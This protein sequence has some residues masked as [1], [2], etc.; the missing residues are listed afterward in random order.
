MHFSE[1]EEANND[2]LSPLEILPD[3]DPLTD[4]VAEHHDLQEKLRR[5]ID[6]LPPKF[7]SVVLLRYASQ[8]SF[9]EIGKVLHM[10]EATAKTYFQRARPL[11]RAALADQR[12]LSTAL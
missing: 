5:A 10:P 11:L 9:S 4:E 6:G 3:T 1:L 12:Q 8:L 2:D 7:R